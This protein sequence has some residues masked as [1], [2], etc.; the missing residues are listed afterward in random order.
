MSVMGKEGNADGQ[1]C[2]ASFMNAG[3]HS[4]GLRQDLATV[5]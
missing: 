3:D 5:S 1:Q 4:R 2:Y